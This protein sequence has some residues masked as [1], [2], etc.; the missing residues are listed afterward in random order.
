MQEAAEGA[1]EEEEEARVEAA[2]LRERLQKA[3]SSGR[4][5]RAH[6]TSA[7]AALDRARAGCIPILREVRSLIRR[8][9]FNE[10]ATCTAPAHWRSSLRAAV[11]SSLIR[12]SKCAE[13]A[14]CAPFLSRAQ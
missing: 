4:M 6:R 1:K 11:R 3:V 8:Y 14:G 5:Y 13:L 10:L 7:E 2:D 12:R 9:L